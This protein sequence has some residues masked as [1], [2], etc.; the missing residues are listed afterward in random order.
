MTVKEL[1]EELQE[2]DPEAVVRFVYH[3]GDHGNSQVA[4]EV[5]SV[6][7]GDV[8]YSEYFSG[9]VVGDENDDEDNIEYAVLLQ[10]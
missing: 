7:D 1:I 2:Q 5:Q 3:Y 4:A 6:E 10:A 8:R 9:F